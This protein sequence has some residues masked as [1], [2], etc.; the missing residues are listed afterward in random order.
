MKM[1]IVQGIYFRFFGNGP[2]YS[3]RFWRVLKEA[4]FVQ[5]F[6]SNLSNFFIR[7]TNFSYIQARQHPTQ[8][9]K[10][11]Y[12]SFSDLER[13]R[14][15]SGLGLH[16]APVLWTAALIQIWLLLLFSDFDLFRLCFRCVS[17]CSLFI[18]FDVFVFDVFRFVF[19]F[20]FDFVSMF[21]SARCPI[22]RII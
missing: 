2:L 13:L 22:R 8:K 4:T 16:T 14:A 1:L 3:P 21:V 9:T 18:L 12:F 19:R 17:M 11:K 10:L 15:C 20:C 5:L 7:C 6:C